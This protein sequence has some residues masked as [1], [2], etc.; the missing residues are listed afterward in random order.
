MKKIYIPVIGLLFV[1]AVFGQNFS[2]VL[3]SNGCL[4][5]ARLNHYDPDRYNLLLERKRVEISGENQNIEF[6]GSQ[7]QIFRQVKPLEKPG[8]YQIEVIFKCL[9]GGVDNASVSVDFDFDNWSKDNY[10]LMPGAVYNGNRYEAVQMDYSPFFNSQSQMGLDKP[11]IIS[12]QPRLNFRDGY[13]R[14]QELSGSMSLPSIGFQSPPTSKG[15][16]L[17]FQQA[18]KLGDYGVDIEENKGRTKA[19]ITLS[20]PLVRELVKAQ[21]MRMDKA[22]SNDQPANFK[23]GDEVTI[24]FSIDFFNAPNIQ[25]LY[26]E[27][28]YIRQKH[29]PSPKLHPL[30]PFSAAYS[31]IAKHQNNE[32]WNTTENYYGTQSVTDWQP[33]WVGGLNT[34][35]AFLAEGDDSTRFRSQETLNWLYQKGMAPSGS[36]YDI[37]RNGVFTSSK[38]PKPFGENLTLTRKQA[39][40]IY[41]AFKQ[42]SLLKM[43]GK[44]VSNEWIK[45]NQ[46]ALDV[47]LSVWKKHSRLGMW[48]NQVNGDLVIGNSTSGGIF[49]AALCEAAAFT[50]DRTY[51]ETAKEIGEYYYQ[52]YVTK[53]LVYGGPGDALQSFDSESSYGLLESFTNLYETTGDRKWLQYSEEMAAQFASWV[54]AYDYQFPANS[55][56]GKMRL[57]TAGTVYANTQNKHTAPGICTHSGIA[58]LKLYRA[59][60]N[61]DYLNM[62]CTIAGTI[63]Q[64]MSFPGHEIPGYKTGWIS[65]RINMT[66]WQSSPPIGGVMQATCWDE[67]SMLLSAV[68]LPGVYVNRETHE[69]FAIDHV[70]AKLN[71][72]GQ[73]E[74][75]NPTPYDAVLKVLAETREQMAKPLGQNAFLGWKKVSIPAGKSVTVNMEK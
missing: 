9:S 25:A 57:Q 15:C 55:I 74:I 2:A 7:W 21:D 37:K 49:P 47:L 42:F 40:A 64:Y 56:M 14:I 50:G 12:D 43:Q 54:V 75:T 17:F 52:N 10:V 59:T 29:N 46:G 35:F 72:K 8:I 13:S 28:T 38:A 62:L 22:P 3:Q 58:L 69:V 19:I 39:E 32:F 23:S 16:W 11:Q 48:I 65:E 68:E 70:E 34:T 36:Y 45:G 53:G 33:A 41:Y 61:P 6:R 71:K 18:N 51:I 44:N 31:I 1:Q 5:S 27:L 73:L 63:P 60:Q 4:L 24:S 66:D 67:T 26:N 20:S 30:I